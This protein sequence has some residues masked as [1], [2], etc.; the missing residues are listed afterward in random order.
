MGTPSDL[1]NQIRDNHPVRSEARIEP[2]GL[3]FQ[4]TT[5]V[6]RWPIQLPLSTTRH[7]NESGQGGI[8]RSRAGLKRTGAFAILVP[9]RDDVI[10]NVPL[11]RPLSV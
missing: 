3:H 10:I 11:V 7:K 5:D 6:I 2:I 9:R 8:H 1:S 4:M